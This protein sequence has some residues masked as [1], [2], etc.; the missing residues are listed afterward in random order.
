MYA[1]IKINKNSTKIKSYSSRTKRGELLI[2]QLTGPGLIELVQ[3]VLLDTGSR[4]IVVVDQIILN[5]WVAIAHGP[6][7]LGCVANTLFEN[8]FYVFKKSLT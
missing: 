5:Q 6:I 1:L 2:A 3:R 8:C 7:R 4:L